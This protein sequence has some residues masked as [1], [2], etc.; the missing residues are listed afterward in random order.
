ML[1]FEFGKAGAI[2]YHPKVVRYAFPLSALTDD[3]PT[4]ERSD[5]LID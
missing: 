5:Q 2:A 1:V 3:Q 4:F